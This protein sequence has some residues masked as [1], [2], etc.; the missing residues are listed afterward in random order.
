[1]AWTTVVEGLDAD[2]NSAS[3]EHPG[4]MASV[5]MQGTFSSGTCK[6]QCSGDDG[7]TW[8][9]VDAT[10]ASKTANG[11]FKIDLA[12]CDLRVNLN[13][14]SSPDIDVLY[15]RYQVTYI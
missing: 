4:G 10:N 9:D 11:V 3:W 15:Q 14:S 5:I 12:D 7:T 8:V 13:G 1:M 2:G 6:L